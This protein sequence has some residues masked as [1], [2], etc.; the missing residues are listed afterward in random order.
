MFDTIFQIIFLAFYLV[1][2]VVRKIFTAKYH[3]VKI[4]KS[5]KTKG[6]A[7]G[8]VFGSIGLIFPL[9]YL[10]TTWFDFANYNQPDFVGWL[11]VP[12]FALAIWL[13]ARSHIDL[14]KNWT[15]ILQITQGHTLVTSGVFKYVRH[16]MYAAH[17]VWGIAQILLLQNWLVGPSMLIFML[18]LMLIRIPKEEKM[19]I[20]QFGQEYQDYMKRAG[21][22]IPKVKFVLHFNFTN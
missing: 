17:L 3:K 1:G 10:F 2:S 11:G 15:P 9:F 21:R 6:D 8:L 4:K 14:G 22:I 12:V 19:M 16:P 18:P 5:Y 20:E 7:V 13:L